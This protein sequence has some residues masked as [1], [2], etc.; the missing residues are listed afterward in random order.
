VGDGCIR[1]LDGYRLR[2][3][4]SLIILSDHAIANVTNG[5]G[6]RPLTAQLSAMR[7]GCRAVPACGSAAL[8]RAGRVVCGRW[9]CAARRGAAR[10]GAVLAGGA[11]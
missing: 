1:F 5:H 4:P 3:A 7:E 6:A 2:A 11:I 10:R 8:G 9:Q